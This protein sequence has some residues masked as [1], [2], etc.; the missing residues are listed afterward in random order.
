MSYSYDFLKECQVFYL[1]TINNGKPA[2]RPFG[3]IA[4]HNGEL[5]FTTGKS[6][7]VYRQLNQN[8][9]IQIVALKLGT[10]NWLRI[11]AYAIEVDDLKIKKKLFEENAILKEHFSSAEE[12]NF[13][14]FKATNKEAYIN[15]DGNFKKIS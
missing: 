6:K 10:R 11:N 8:S 2:G 9:N 4:E 14:L 5:Y 7:E 1:I 15:I 13:A 3:F 12:D